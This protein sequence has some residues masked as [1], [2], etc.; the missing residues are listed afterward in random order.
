MHP[1]Q[2][3]LPCLTVCSF[4]GRRSGPGYRV[5][6]GWRD[7]PTTAKFPW[8][9]PQEERWKQPHGRF[10]QTAPVATGRSCCQ[11]CQLLLS[12]Q[13]EGVGRVASRGTAFQMNNLFPRTL[14]VTRHHLLVKGKLWCIL[15]HL[16]MIFFLSQMFFS[17]FALLPE[18]EYPNWACWSYCMAFSR[19]L[20]CSWNYASS[21]SGDAYCDWQL[22]PNF[23]LWTGNFCVPACF[24]MRIPKSCV[25]VCPYHEKRNRPGFVNISPTVVHNIIDTS[26]ERSSRVLHH[27]N[28][29]FDFLKKRPCLPEC[30]CCHVL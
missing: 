29:K 20:I 23:E 13:G 21:S 14:L 1:R 12:R 10:S 5:A 3:C 17:F 11:G 8:Q 19:I 9:F 25:S 24:Q 27:G 22:T 28:P 30:F 16:Q 26:M 15:Q 18:E 4:A 2:E 7:G 6:R